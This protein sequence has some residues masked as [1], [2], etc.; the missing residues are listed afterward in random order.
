[1][2]LLQLSQDDLKTDDSQTKF[3]PEIID[4]LNNQ[5]EDSDLFNYLNIAAYGVLKMDLTNNVGTN[6]L[7]VSFQHGLNFKPVFLAY[8]IADPN[9]GS[10]GTPLPTWQ[11]LGY[12]PLNGLTFI[13]AYADVQN[14]NITYWR[15]GGSGFVLFFQY[16]IFN[17]PMPT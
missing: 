4:E 13:Y 6:N 2:A 17:L 8:L 12:Q 9:I 14:L 3:I 5:Q 10:G 7:T 1:M 11:T 16:Y 15:A